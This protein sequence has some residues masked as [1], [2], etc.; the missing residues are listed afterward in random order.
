[1]ETLSKTSPEIAKALEIVDKQMLNENGKF[2]LLIKNGGVN[3]EMMFALDEN[4]SYVTDAFQDNGA[5]ISNDSAENSIVRVNN[6]TPGEQMVIL[7]STN[8]ELEQ[9]KLDNT[10]I[11]LSNG[12]A[13]VKKMEDIRDNSIVDNEAALVNPLFLV[14]VVVTEA[15]LLGF[16]LFMIFTG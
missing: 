7:D 12:M 1:M 2:Q 5:M 15:L 16:F 4:Y 9:R 8:K 3:H 10:D 11:V 14:L 6:T 13:Y